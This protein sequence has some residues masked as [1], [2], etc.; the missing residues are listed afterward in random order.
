MWLAQAGFLPQARIR[1]RV[2]R[3]CLVITTE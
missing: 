2:M 3:G 1:V